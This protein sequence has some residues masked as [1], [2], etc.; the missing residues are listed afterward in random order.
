MLG[1]QACSLPDTWV[2]DIK[3]DEN[4]DFT[5]QGSDGSAREIRGLMTIRYQDSIFM[6]LVSDDANPEILRYLK[7][8]IEDTIRFY[9]PYEMLILN[10][11][12]D[13]PRIQRIFADTVQISSQ[14]DGV[15]P[16]SIIGKR[17]SFPCDL[18][19]R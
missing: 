8:D 13:K 16:E 3:C 12:S 14:E 2:Y 18:R 9:D 15:A 1:A 17:A 11:N 5:Y 19:K 10:F 4:V 7:S 6:S